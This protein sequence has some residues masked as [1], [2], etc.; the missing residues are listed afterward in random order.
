MPCPWRPNRVKVPGLVTLAVGVFNLALALFLAKVLGWGLYGLAGAGAISLTL[1]RFVFT[2][3]YVA[4]VLHQPYRT[5]TAGGSHHRGTVSTIALCR[6]LSRLGP[7]QPGWIGD[8]RSG[9]L[10]AVCA[11]TCLLSPPDERSALEEYPA[12]RVICEAR[13][14]F[15]IDQSPSRRF[16]QCRT[17]I[18]REKQASDR[19]NS[20]E[21]AA[22]AIAKSI[23]VE[24][25]PSRD[26][27]TGTSNR[28]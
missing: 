18:R 6:W 19:R 20:K 13:S 5:Y 10:L 15:S 9:G 24:M 12:R 8:G 23:R 16:L 25:V 4:A 2:P 28:G 11:I 14:H 22:A 1:R 21:T 26:Q 17:F 3:L 7:F 27:P